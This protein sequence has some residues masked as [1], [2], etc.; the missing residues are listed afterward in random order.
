MRTNFLRFYYITEILFSPIRHPKLAISSD[1]QGTFWSF[2]V[3]DSCENISTNI[4]PQNLICSRHGRFGENDIIFC[5]HFP[6]VVNLLRW[7]MFYLFYIVKDRGKPAD[8]SVCTPT[9]TLHIPLPLPGVRGF[10]RV[11]AGMDGSD[12]YDGYLGIQS[13]I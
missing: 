9:L 12:G 6:L 3:R 10:L 4:F 7:E 13:L 8:I 5:A 11:L 2:P 1:F